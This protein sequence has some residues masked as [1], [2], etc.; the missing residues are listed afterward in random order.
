MA[1]GL[2]TMGSAASRSMWNPCSVWKVFS[3]SAGGVGG[4]DGNLNGSAQ[5]TVNGRRAASV[6]RA[7]RSQKALRIG[8]GDGIELRI[9]QFGF[10]EFEFRGFEIKH[11]GVRTE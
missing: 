11:R 2:A 4:I 9:G 8:L 7:L 5:N 3:A 6:T 1:T 10:T